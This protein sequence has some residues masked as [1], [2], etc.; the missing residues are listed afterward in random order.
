VL[1]I[2]QAFPQIDWDP[3][4]RTLW[5]NIGDGSPNS[6]NEFK[7]LTELCSAIF[8]Y[9]NGPSAGSNGV[10][11]LLSELPSQQ[12]PQDSDLHNLRLEFLKRVFWGYLQD[13]MVFEIKDVKEGMIPP[14]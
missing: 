11:N 13:M 3:T 10:L 1:R 8:V 12:G 5:P 14:D 2:A 6:E 4:D 9:E 7:R